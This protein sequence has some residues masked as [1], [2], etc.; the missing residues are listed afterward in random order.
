M[1]PVIR[2]ADLSEGEMCSV[3]VDGIDVLVCNVEG[4]FYAMH[5][6]CSHARQKLS[7]GRLRGYEV[8]CPL[9]GARFDVRD[10]SVK[11]PP[12][13]RPV[14]GFPVLLQDGKVHITITEVDQPA[15]PRFGPMN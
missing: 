10:G 15:P 2:M 8:A 1:K 11:A 9:H 7:Q 13:N 12:A 4:Q 3:T 5:N 6:Q 14:T